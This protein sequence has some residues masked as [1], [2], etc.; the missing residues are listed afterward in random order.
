ME[1]AYSQIAVNRQFQ[2]P[3]IVYYPQF[4]D[5]FRAVGAGKCRYG[6]LPIENSSYGSVNEVY[7]LMKQYRFPIVR[8]LKLRISHNLLARR[9]PLSAI[10]GRSIPMG[11]RLGSAAHSLRP[12]PES[13]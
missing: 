3:E 6:V 1:G 12:I 2:Y 8:G 11:R 7:D 13:G 9:G 10:S 4:E 5:V